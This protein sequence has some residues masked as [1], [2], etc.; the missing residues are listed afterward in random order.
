MKRAIRQILSLIL[1]PMMFGFGAAAQPQEP[2]EGSEQVCEDTLTTA[3]PAPTIADSIISDAMAYLGVPYVY[4]GTGASGFDCSGLAYRVFGD[5]G[6]D[7]PRTVSGMESIG[8][9]VER[10]DL[11]PGDLLIFHDPSHVGLYMGDGEFIHCSSYLDRGV[12]ITALSQP[13][14]DRRYHSARR[15]LLPEQGI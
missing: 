15:V 5:N 7:L 1:L 2:E 8:E 13:N 14:Y 10:E 9:P 11:I 6:I 4:G 12:V 3:V